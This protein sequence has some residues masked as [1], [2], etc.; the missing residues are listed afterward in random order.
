MLIK[1]LGS[2]LIALSGTYFSFS[3]CKFQRKRLQ[4]LD[5]Y[6]SLL[7]FIKGQID[8]YLRP[9]SEILGMADE[10]IIEGCGFK[11]STPS[12]LTEMLPYSRI[13][14]EDESRRLLYNFSEEFGSTY[15]DEQL[16]RCDY[17]IESLLVERNALCD[18][19]PSRSKAGSALWMCTSFALMIMLW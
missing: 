8:C 18:E 1:L 7:F 4:V 12:S 19:I 16:K 10:R 11:K 2:L 15:K 9:I 5:S 13:Y 6:I 14:L 17:Y 3:F